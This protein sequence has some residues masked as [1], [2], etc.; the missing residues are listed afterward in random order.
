MSVQKVND[1][2][3]ADMNHTYKFS[4]LLDSSAVV[5]KNVTVD[6]NGTATATIANTQMEDGTPR[7][8][9][10][11]NGVTGNNIQTITA[12]FPASTVA[13]T[14]PTASTH[15]VF[16]NATQ[17]SAANVDNAIYSARITSDAAGPLTVVVSRVG[18]GVTA[19]DL[20]G[21]GVTLDIEL[22]KRGISL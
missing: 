3:V 8:T 18:N 22:R 17:Q 6:N 2:N 15:D 14:A 20:V 13:G 19:A 11:V 5:A 10:I 4:L 7:L 1:Q 21:V 9:G 12:T 16:V